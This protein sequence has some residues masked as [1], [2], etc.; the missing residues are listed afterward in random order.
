MTTTRLNKRFTTLAIAGFLAA[1]A[2][3]GASAQASPATQST[4]NAGLG[5]TWQFQISLE[6]CE[7]KAT[8]GAPFYSLLTFNGNGTMTE[9]TSNPMFYPAERGPGHGVWSQVNGT[10]YNATSEAFITLN[11]EL[12][13]VQTI[14]QTIEMTGKDTLMTTSAKVKFAA[15]DGTVLMEGCASATASRLGLTGVQ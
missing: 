1:S 11:G 4:P 8:V 5:G 9:T 15:P 10:T 12:Q 3:P 2:M 7:T 13:K 14:T 6:N